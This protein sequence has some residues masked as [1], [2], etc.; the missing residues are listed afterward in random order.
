MPREVF[1]FSFF[2]FIAAPDVKRSLVLL[3][4]EIAFP[5]IIHVCAVHPG[6]ELCIVVA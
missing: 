5:G 6:S 1:F 2:S 3:M 4:N